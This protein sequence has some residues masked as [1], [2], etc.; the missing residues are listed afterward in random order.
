MYVEDEISQFITVDALKNPSESASAKWLSTSLT[1][2][3][4]QVKAVRRI[5]GLYIRL[6]FKISGCVQTSV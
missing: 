3:A 5:D 4:R 1:L 2:L 6:Q